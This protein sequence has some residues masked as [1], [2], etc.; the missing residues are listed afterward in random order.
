MQTLST[1]AQLRQLVSGWR[2]QGERIAL[3]PTMG[4]LHAGHLQLVSEAKSKADRVVV[5][6]FVN[7]MQF[8]DAEGK[9]GDFERYPRTLEQDLAKLSEVDAVFAP[10]VQEVYPNGFENE[11]RVEVPGISDILCG[12]YRPGHFTGVATVVAKL[13]NMVQPDR[14]FF[15]EKDFQQLQVIRRMA[16]DLCFPVE[17]I[18]VPTVREQD[19]LAMSSRNQYL[20][21][22]ER[23][24]AAIIYQ[25]LLWLKEQWLSGVRDITV[26]QG[27]ASKQLRSAGFRPD[28][29]AIRRAEDLAEAGPDDRDIVILIAAWLGTARL[30]DNLLLESNP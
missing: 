18:G 3:V 15:G 16:A 1:I 4:N 7:P 10:A 20:N 27:Q 26:L 8:V 29:V 5:S 11:T 17:V 24:Q 12:E 23:K 14:A 28:Y 22:E 13:F 6:I 30:I 25:T 9:L 19:G 21:R 2:Q